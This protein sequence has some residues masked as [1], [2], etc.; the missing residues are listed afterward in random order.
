MVFQKTLSLANGLNSLKSKL[1]A[2]GY[3]G[4]MWADEI[5]SKAPGANWTTANTLDVAIGGAAM[6]ALDD[7][8]RLAPGDKDLRDPAG[9]IDLTQIYYYATDANQRVHVQISTQ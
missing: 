3:T 8:L 1:V 2:A 5:I 7:G 9:K 4:P 6:A